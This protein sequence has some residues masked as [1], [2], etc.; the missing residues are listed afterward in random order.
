MLPEISPTGQIFTQQAPI[1]ITVIDVWLHAYWEMVRNNL[2]TVIEV[3]AL[4]EAS[5]LSEALSGCIDE[6]V[7]S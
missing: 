3:A 1:F 4:S 6:D 5:A 7:A 2:I